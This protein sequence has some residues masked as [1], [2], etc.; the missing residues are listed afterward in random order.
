MILKRG[1]LALLPSI[2]V[3]SAAWAQASGWNHSRRREGLRGR[4]VAGRDGHG[5]QP[6]HGDADYGGQHD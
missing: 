1:L 6:Q 5:D 4:R 2:G 3:A